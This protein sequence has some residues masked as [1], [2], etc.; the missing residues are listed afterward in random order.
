MAGQGMGFVNHCERDAEKNGYEIYG[1]YDTKEE[2]D[3]ILNQI[4]GCGARAFKAHHSHW[5][6][7]LDF[8]L[9]YIKTADLDLL[10]N[11]QYI[12]EPKEEEAKTPEEK[13]KKTAQKIAKLYE[14]DRIKL[15]DIAQMYGMNYQVVRNYYSMYKKGKFD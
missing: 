2:V 10:A 15:K 6:L 9:L 3:H 11:P 12:H 13:R 7:N 8:W 4:H 5:E 14:E 1:R